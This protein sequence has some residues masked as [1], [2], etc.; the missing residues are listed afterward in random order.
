[1]SKV[2]HQSLAQYPVSKGNLP[3]LYQS[4][5]PPQMKPEEAECAGRLLRKIPNEEHWNWDC[6]RNPH[7]TKNKN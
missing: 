5:H 6:I 7:E 3:T 4:N 2:Y 1:M